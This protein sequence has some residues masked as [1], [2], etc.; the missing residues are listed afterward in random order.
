MTSIGSKLSEEQLESLLMQF[1]YHDAVKRVARGVT[2]SYNNIF[3]GLAGQTAMLRQETTL[4]GDLAD[5]RGELMTEL[6]QRGIEQTAILFGFTRDADCE[7]RI[8]SPLLVAAKALE[9]LNS[10]SRIHRFL[11]RSEL[12]Q[13]KFH[14]NVRDITLLLFYLGENCVD[15]TP[16]GGTI[17]LDIGW[18]ENGP[19]PSERG[20]AFRFRDHGQGF[21]E[22][23]PLSFKTPFVTSRTDSPF[24]GLG[25]Y[26]AQILAARYNGHLTIARNGDKETVVSA[27]FP[28]AMKEVTAPPTVLTEQKPQPEEH[29]LTKQC[30][31]VVEDDEAMRTLLLNRLQRRGHM[32][33]CVDTCTEAL[34]EYNY[35]HDIITTVLMDVGLQDASGYECHRKI[36][37]I[38][39][40]ARIIFM[41]GQNEMAPA[42]LAGKLVFLQKPFTI[43]QL[44]KAVHD[45]H[46]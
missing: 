32:V 9:L 44:E 15:A 34:E 39:P 25:L 1:K 14:G 35:L 28:A 23:F 17:F 37:A 18:D 36:L 20:V 42:E 45:A 26:S 4:L 30:F 24:R 29:S 43:D 40:K 7:N 13:E 3:T 38:N 8:Q 41:S 6:L 10:I 19:V 11:L 16:K 22:N 31:L 5:K 27:V 12:K 2:H 33:F 21:A 46:V